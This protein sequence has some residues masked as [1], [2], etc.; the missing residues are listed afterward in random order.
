MFSA[1]AFPSL[2]FHL[3]FCKMQP[4]AK[5]MGLVT[6]L[7]RKASHLIPRNSTDSPL[8]HSNRLLFQ[9]LMKQ[10]TSPGT[11]SFSLKS[12]CR[13]NTLSSSFANLLEVK[14]GHKMGLPD[15][16]PEIWRILSQP[17]TL[18]K[19]TNTNKHKPQ[20]NCFSIVLYGKQ[21]INQSSW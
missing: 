21:I 18:L 3:S 5:G 6:Q 13:S 14:T 10:D 19:Q 1:T 17:F 15:F 12:L 11:S 8:P 9:T 2:S 20:V 4:I 16:Y 7:P